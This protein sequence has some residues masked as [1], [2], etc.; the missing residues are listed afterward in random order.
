MYVHC[1]KVW[2]GWFLGGKEWHN[3]K[4]GGVCNM[5]LLTYVLL[6]GRAEHMMLWFLLV[7]GYCLMVLSL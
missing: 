7:P 1:T 5:I 3:L 6:V 4:C 2:P